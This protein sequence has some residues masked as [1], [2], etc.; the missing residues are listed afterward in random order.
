MVYNRDNLKNNSNGGCA[1]RR[2]R[3]MSQ[4]FRLRNSLFLVRL[5]RFFIKSLQSEY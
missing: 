4:E 3:K 1:L 5:Y 2:K